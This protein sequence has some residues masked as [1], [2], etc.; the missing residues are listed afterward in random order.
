MQCSTQSSKSVV[1][2]TIYITKK[3]GIKSAKITA[4]SGNILTLNPTIPIEVGD[5]WVIHKDV[6]SRLFRTVSITENTDEGTYSISAVSHDPSKYGEVDNAANFPT[7]INKADTVEINNITV[8]D[9]GGKINVGWDGSL[10]GSYISYDV[11]VY[12]NGTFYRHTPDAKTPNI[13]LSGLPCGNYRLEIR[14][15]TVKG[16]LSEPQIKTFVIDYTITGFR[17]QAG[18]YSIQLYWSNPATVVNQACTEIFSSTENR[19]DTAKLLVSIP[20]PTST[21]TVQNVRLSDRFFFWA[22][23]KDET[24]V[25]GDFT[26]VIEA[27][28]DPD[29]Q[30]ILDQLNGSLSMDQFKPE[31]AEELLQNIPDFAGDS[32]E[33]AGDGR[34]L[35]GKW[36][37]YSQV[38]SSD[39]A[40]TK[41]IRAVRSQFE[42]NVATVAEQITTLAD[43]QH[44]ESEKLSVVAAQVNNTKAQVT[45]VSKSFADLSGKLSATWQVQV[46]VDSGSGQPIVGGVQL[47]VESATGKSEFV[48]QADKFAVW[49]GKK[50]PLFTAQEGIMGLNG[51]LVLSGTLSGKTLIGNELRGGQINGGSLNIGNGRFVVSP[52]GTV[53]IRDI[54]WANRGLVIT[55]QNILVFDDSGV[56]RTKIGRL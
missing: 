17:A 6:K 11:K 19:I 5:V 24:G 37:V 32:S 1:G 8:S 47:G 25:T 45:E 53:N 30:P 4:Q 2:G 12:R 40:L 36:D 3:D 52:D 35:A 29:P 41:Q 43:K 13:E 18:L 46:S 39:Y 7:T 50:V 20:Y 10:S 23:F 15:R 49:S 42:Q 14:G 44:A 21:Y 31:V 56:L 51:D 16:N 22:R 48:V 55:S 28:A 9:E 27:T 34:P 33:M 38:T 54:S 26:Q